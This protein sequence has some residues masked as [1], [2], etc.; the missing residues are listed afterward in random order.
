MN[1]ILRPVVASQE[2]SGL[3]IDVI[4]VKPGPGAHSLRPCNPIEIL[5]GDA[6]IVEFTHGIGL[7]VDTNSK[8]THS[9]DRFKDDAGHPNLVEREGCSSPPMPPPAIITTLS[10][11]N[12]VRSANSSFPYGYGAAHRPQGSSHA[13]GLLSAF[14]A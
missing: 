3:G 9:P 6:E 13:S 1:S 10:V 7:Q 8:R 12:G 11:I 4:A 14:S 2:P 5:L